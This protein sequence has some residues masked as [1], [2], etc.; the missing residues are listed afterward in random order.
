MVIVNV[1][2]TLVISSFRGLLY[3]EVVVF[4][5]EILSL[6]VFFFGDVVNVFKFYLLLL[7]VLSNFVV[8]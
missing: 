6:I 3:F 7:S 5:V 2:F 4:V 1:F 8:I